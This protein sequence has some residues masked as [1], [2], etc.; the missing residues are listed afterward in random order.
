MKRV[1]ITLIVLVALA[2][3]VAGFILLAPSVVSE[4]SVGK[5]DLQNLAFQPHPGA[6]LPLATDFIDENGREAALGAYFSKSPVV[7]V[8]EYLRCTSL[9]GVTLRSIVGAL[10]DLPL[11]SGRDYQLVAISID[12]R[13]TPADAATAREKYA[14]VLGRA[15]AAAGLHFLTA[16]P[17]AVQQIA[18]AIGFPYR[19]DRLLDAYIHPAG[20]VIATPAGVISRYV[21][22]IATSPQ[23]LLGAFADAQQNKTPGLLERL[24][25]FCHIQGAP[26]GRFTVP[27]LGAMMLAEIAAALAALTIFTAIRRRPG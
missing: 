11:V 12:P 2:T 4:A 1:A 3:G 26:L 21:E 5:D 24:I 17:A 9:C 27:V 6:Q 8:L 25:L 16:A 14:A 20:F 13:D 7:I 22:G 18:G 23:Q 15:D 10:A 19:Y